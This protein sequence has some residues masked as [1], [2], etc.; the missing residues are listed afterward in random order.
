L[1]GTHYGG[2]GRVTFGLPDLR[3]RGPVGSSMMGH[4]PGLATYP[5]GARLGAQEVVLGQTHLPRHNHGASF[6]QTPG[7]GATGTLEAYS[8]GASNSQCAAGDY[9]SGGGASPTFGTGGLGAELVELSG[10]TITNG[11]PGGGTV[12]VQDSGHNE[13]FE[14]INPIQALNFVVCL[15][16]LYP[17]RP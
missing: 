11:A 15:Q 3:G 9:I 10:L 14:I 6:E 8:A 1:L 13:P 7:V 12:T 17:S 16:G 5:L 4:G 2:D